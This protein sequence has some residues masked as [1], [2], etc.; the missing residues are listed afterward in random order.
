ME[1]KCPNCGKELKVVIEGTAKNFTCKY[2]GYSF[3][4]SVTEGI[5]W[6]SKEYTIILERNNKTT[7]NQIKMI[8]QLSSYNFIE[9]KNLLINGGIL[10]S[11]RAIYVKKVIKKLKEEDIKFSVIPEFVY[12]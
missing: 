8:S 4:T 11:G 10:N 1:N 2:C 3:A 12:D 9:S 5:E 6:D 7:L